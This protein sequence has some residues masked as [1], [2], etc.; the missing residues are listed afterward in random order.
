M[1]YNMN[2][3]K[4]IQEIF[5]DMARFKR[6]TQGSQ[7]EAKGIGFSRSQL[8]LLFTVAHHER[9]SG[10]QIADA[11]GISTSAASQLIDP[12]VDQGLLARTEDE[13]D[14]RITH[15]SFTAKGKTALKDVKAGYLARMASS[16]DALSD[17]D[18]ETLQRLHRKMLDSVLKQ[19]GKEGR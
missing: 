6:A 11:L 3:S 18:L 2:R 19:K 4:L 15:I 10:R 9:M 7:A 13:R 14:R 8:E 17:K 5:E 16:M 1:V 12:L